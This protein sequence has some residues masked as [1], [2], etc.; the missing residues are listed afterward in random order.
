MPIF[1][2]ELQRPA[3]VLVAVSEHR[4]ARAALDRFVA[5]LKQVRGSGLIVVLRN[6]QEI[7]YRELRELGSK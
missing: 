6:G 3:G 2:L 4:S 1:R 7:T 5:L